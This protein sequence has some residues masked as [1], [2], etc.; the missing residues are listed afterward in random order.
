MPEHIGPAWTRNI[1]DLEPGISISAN[2]FIVGHTD[3][4]GSYEHNVD[5]S[6][7]R[8]AAVVAALVKDFKIDAK[9]PQTIGIGPA[10]PISSNASEADRAGNRR[11]EM[12]LR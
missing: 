6:S 11:V 12:V 3:T 5:L 8:A 2:V 10:A 9:R 7:R 4:V 1:V